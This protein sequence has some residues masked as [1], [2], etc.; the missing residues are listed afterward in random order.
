[1]LW[2][3]ASP[4]QVVGGEGVGFGYEIVWGASMPLL[5]GEKG[6]LRRDGSSKFAAAGGDCHLS[7]ER[8]VGG[9]RFVASAELCC[10]N[11]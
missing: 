11:V 6:G 5:G 7:F 9:T 10:L 4:R 2:V 1:M 3:E 8:R